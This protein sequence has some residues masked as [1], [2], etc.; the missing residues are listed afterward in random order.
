MGSGDWTDEM[1]QG[2]IFATDGSSPWGS[3]NRIFVKCVAVGD[4][5]GL[6]IR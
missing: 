2:G 3:A 5:E 1:A 6:H 4:L